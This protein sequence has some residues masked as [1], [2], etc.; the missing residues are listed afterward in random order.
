MIKIKYGKYINRH[1]GKPA[2]HDPFGGNCLKVWKATVKVSIPV[3]PITNGFTLGM[4]PN[5]TEVFYFLTS[6]MRI[7]VSSS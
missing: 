5:F 1:T 2:E 3:L 4:F 6:R 7:T